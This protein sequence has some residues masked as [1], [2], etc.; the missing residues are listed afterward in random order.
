MFIIGLFVWSFIFV[1]ALTG[2]LYVLTPQ[3]EE[4]L[5]THRL[6][7]DVPSTTQPLAAQAALTK[8]PS[9]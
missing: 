2:T 5:Y 4:R 7:V 6:H 3:I 1:A 9:A 8:Q